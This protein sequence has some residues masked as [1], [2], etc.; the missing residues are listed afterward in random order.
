MA[1]NILI[2][3][4]EGQ[5]GKSLQR[6]LRDKFEVVPTDLITTESGSSPHIKYLDITERSDVVRTI[7]EINPD[8][9]INCA[10]YTDVDG[11][12]RN[13]NKAYLV[14]VVG[15]EN[16]LNASDYNTY[17]IQI[18][19]DY[20]FDGKGGPYSEEDHTY[21]I[22]FYGK[23]K[24]EAEN[25]LSGSRRE[26]LII[27]PNVLY[28]EDLFVKGNFFSWVYKSLLN[29]KPISVVMDQISNPT[30]VPHLAHA[31][32]QCILLNTTGIYH[33][34]S[35][36][37]IS[38]YEFALAIAENLELDSSLITAINSEELALINPSYISQRPRH[39]GLK[40]FKIEDEIGLTIHSI[41]YCINLLKN[42]IVTT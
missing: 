13:K 37:Y 36:D 16:L 29:N 42:S 22:N 9:I 26:Y 8:I 3:G 20:V 5:L 39:S 15:L 27:R 2:T 38:R 19:S 12:E 7:N 4:A 31:I 32:F 17:F 30:Y 34:G 11:S 33:F 35:D 24:L 10:A 14:N 40:T 25:I 23:T 18:S 21:P 41:D 28:C 6:I 1:R